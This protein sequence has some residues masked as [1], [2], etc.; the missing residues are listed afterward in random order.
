MKTND[1]IES[2][3]KMNDYSY[4]KIAQILE[5]SQSGM[6][7]YRKGTRFFDDQTAIKVA[8]LLDIN[9]EIVLADI[10]AERSK[11]RKTRKVWENIAKSLRASALLVIITVVFLQSPVKT[12]SYGYNDRTIYIM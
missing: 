7:K 10:H 12:E 3:Y 2:I 5:I 11:I 9:P 1:Y 6:S 4:Y 8:E